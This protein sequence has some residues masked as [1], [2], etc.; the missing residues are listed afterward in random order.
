MPHPGLFDYGQKI[1]TE[2]LLEC[3]FQKFHPRPPIVLA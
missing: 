2:T 3:G 1:Q